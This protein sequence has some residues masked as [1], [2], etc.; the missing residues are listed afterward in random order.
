MNILTLTASPFFGG[1]ERQMIG[2]AETLRRLHPDVRSMIAS[3]SEKGNACPFLEKAAAA[4]FEAMELQNDFPHLLRAKKE[5]QTLLRER[6]IDL[7]LANGHKARCIAWLV[8]RSGNVPVIGVSRGWTDENFKIRLYNRFDLFLLRRMRHIVSVSDGQAEK[9]KRFGIPGDRITVI[10]NSIRTDRFDE[11][12]DISFRQTLEAMFPV[13]PRF[14]LGA[15][16]RLSPEKG[17]DVLIEAMKKLFERNIAAGLVIFGDGFLR[18]T[19]KNQAKSSGVQ[20]MVRFPGFTGELDR[21]LPNFDL[22]VQSSRTEGLPN[23]L[24]ESMA[25]QTAVVATRVGGTPEVVEEGV[26]GL[27]VAPENANELAAAITKLLENPERLADM[28]AFGKKRVERL[29]TFDI[30]AEQYYELFRKYVQIKG[31]RNFSPF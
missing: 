26:T 15:A 25:A 19:L 20:N 14:L 3:F 8:A 5:L 4:G 1:P 18:E 16:G 6:Q 12:P 2:L 24:L 9:M 29:F 17:F 11:K 27:M 30:Q 10:R 13:K 7:I 21:F 31:D 22:F 23:V 28:G